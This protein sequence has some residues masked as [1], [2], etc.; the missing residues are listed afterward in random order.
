MPCV[1]RRHPPPTHC[2]TRAVSQTDAAINPGNSGGPLLD[3]S[4]YVIGMTTAIYS[5]SGA[6]NGVGFAVPVDAIRTSVEQI[7]AN[8]RVVRPVMGIG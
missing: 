1:S 3:S 7:L 6:S 4:G 2:P 5:A 8:G